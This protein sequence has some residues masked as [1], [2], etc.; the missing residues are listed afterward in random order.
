MTTARVVVVR[1]GQSEANVPPLWTSAHHGYPLT[2]LGHEQARA[3]GELLRGRGVEAVYASRIQRA[4]QTAAA[5]AQVLGLEPRTLPGVEEI[6]VGVHEGGHNDE[7]GPIA[8]EVF[9]RW[10][11]DGDLDHGFEGG[12]T[13][14]SIATRMRTALDLVADDHQPGPSV[15]VSHGGVMAVGITEMCP[16]LTPGFVSEHFL[17]NTGV[18]ELERD[19]DGWH[20]LSWDGLDPA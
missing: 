2:E 4:Q 19:D 18:V 5:I 13:G 15:V 20:C 14:R 7:V 1:H 6:D 16:E 11:R 9:G 10:W 12:E 17:P 3:A 8:I